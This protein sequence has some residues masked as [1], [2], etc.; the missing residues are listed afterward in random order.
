MVRLRNVGVFIRNW[1][2]GPVDRSGERI[3]FRVRG[4]HRNAG[5]FDCVDFALRAES[6]SLRMTM[7]GCLPTDRSRALGFAFA[8]RPKAAVPT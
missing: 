4:G 1:M 6:T 2:R 3:P 7:G 8:G 5:S